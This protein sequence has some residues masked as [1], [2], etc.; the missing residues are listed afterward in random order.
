[1]LA[2]RMG[3]PKDQIE[4]YLASYQKVKQEAQEKRSALQD[5]ARRLIQYEKGTENLL[6]DGW[7][8]GG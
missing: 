4:D 8:G 1:M 7:A 2:R 5:A 3:K 6:L